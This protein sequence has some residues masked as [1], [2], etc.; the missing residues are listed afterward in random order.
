MLLFLT[1]LFEK[2]NIT[3]C[4]TP[5]TAEELCR[6]F[7]RGLNQSFMET[8]INK[9]ISYNFCFRKILNDKHCIN[10]N[11]GEIMQKIELR[12][13]VYKSF[14]YNDIKSVPYLDSPTSLRANNSFLEPL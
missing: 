8:K 9:P 2:Q 4:K 5:E 1:V 6:H 12:S 13:L 11:R 3:Q 7:L 10:T 14:V